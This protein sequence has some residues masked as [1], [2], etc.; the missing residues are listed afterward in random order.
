M[1][2]YEVIGDCDWNFEVKVEGQYVYNP[3]KI[4]VKARRCY[5]QYHNFVK[6]TVDSNFTYY[7]FDFTISQFTLA[8]V[9]T[10]AVRKLKRGSGLTRE[11]A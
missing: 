9:Y 7:D 3:W 8:N 5:S 10:E 1:A 11:M 6:N 2:M 4:F